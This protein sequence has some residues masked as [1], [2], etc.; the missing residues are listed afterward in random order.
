MAEVFGLDVGDLPDGWQPVE[1]LCIVSCVAFNDDE[2]GTAAR[3]LSIRATEG[4]TVWE[5]IGMLEG[6]AADAR[7]QFL[8]TLL[9]EDGNP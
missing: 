8:A 2:G 5:V 3:K 1:A 6:Y 7:Q 4:L 9:D